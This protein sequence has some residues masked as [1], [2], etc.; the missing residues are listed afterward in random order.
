MKKG[1]EVK[2]PA[3]PAAL[4]RQD[5]VWRDSRK[6]E[7]IATKKWGVEDIPPWPPP[8]NTLLL[9]LPGL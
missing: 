2:R 4:S 6:R 3:P 5:S 8:R 7:L 1:G 9:P